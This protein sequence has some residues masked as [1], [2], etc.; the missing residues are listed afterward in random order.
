MKLIEIGLII[1]CLA[2]IG[3]AATVSVTAGFGAQGFSVTTDG[4]TSLPSFLVAVGGY[5]GGVFT[6]FGN[7]ANDTGKVSGSFTASSPASLNNQV[8]NLFVGNG[9]TVE[10]STSWVILT[11][12]VPLLFPPDVSGTG[13][14]TYSATVGTAQTLV[15]TSNATWAPTQTLGGVAGNGTI[16]FVPE[17]SAA[18][19]GAL[20]ALGLLR[21]RRI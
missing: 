5:S 6:Q 16:T 7:T 17:P 13:G 18:L 8:V 12:T 19:L 1:G 3:N 10:N 2:T 21:R 14:P 15:A 11:P 9:T 20:G 4:T